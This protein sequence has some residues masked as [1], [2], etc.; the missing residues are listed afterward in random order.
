MNGHDHVNDI[1]PQSSIWKETIVSVIKALCLQYER[2]RSCQ[3]SRPC[4]FNIK[5]CDHVTDIDPMASI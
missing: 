3:W 4:V 1:D 2:G 5:V